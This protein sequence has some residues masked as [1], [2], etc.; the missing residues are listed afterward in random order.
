[1][2]TRLIVGRDQSNDCSAVEQGA[3]MFF[4]LSTSTRCEINNDAHIVSWLDLWTP[5]MVH[6]YGLDL[7]PV[8]RSHRLEALFLFLF[9]FVSRSFNFWDDNI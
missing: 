5:T 7:S 9:F 4:S 6:K 2:V 8:L 1:M 3:L